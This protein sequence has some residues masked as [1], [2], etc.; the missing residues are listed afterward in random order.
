MATAIN[1][2]IVQ[3]SDFDVSIVATD[4]LN[5]GINLT[6]YSVFSGAKHRYGDS[7]NFFSFTSSIPNATAGEVNLKLTPSQTEAI[8]AGQ[9]VYG[10]ELK[11]GTDIAFKV[12]KGL[13]NVS[14]EVNN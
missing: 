1:L 14:P 11:K 2:N 3:G 5:V 6:D 8:P 10:I 12:M 7:D 4:D 9:Y 13:V